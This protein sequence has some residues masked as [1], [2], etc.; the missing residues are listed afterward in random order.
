M[1]DA[2]TA[3]LLEELR[4]SLDAIVAAASAFETRL[5]GPLASGDGAALAKGSLDVLEV[6]VLLRSIDARLVR[7]ERHLA[8]DGAAIR[9]FP[10]EAPGSVS[11]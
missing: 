5:Q 9:L 10:P 7:I 11:L 4:R 3:Q 1:S 8:I 2:T 6:L